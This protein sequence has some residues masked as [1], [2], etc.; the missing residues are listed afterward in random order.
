[1]PLEGRRCLLTGATG[2]IGVELARA[3]VGARV[4]LMLSGRQ[5]E[6]LN[7]L[8]E[9]LPYGS[10]IDV[11]AADLLQP[12]E[13]ER[14]ADTAR[15]AKVDTL[16]NLSG[17]NELTWLEDQDGAVIDDM[18]T[19]NLIAPIQL[20]RMLLGH[21]RESSGDGRDGLVVNVGSAFGAIGHAG[22]TAY[23]ASKFGL[24]GFSEALHRELKGN[25]VEV[26]YVAPRATQTAMNAGA[27]ESLNDALGNRSDAP[28]WVADQIVRVMREGRRSANFGWPERFFIRLNQLF[29]AVVDRAM[30]KQQA[31]IRQFARGS[32]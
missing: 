18:L 10:V 1:M 29:P 26:V 24:R 28:E 7:A 11:V 4:K 15:G 8:E 32:K 16:V 6:R 14:L 13:V 20:T 27:A 21:L 31:A 17:A 5:E 19:L 23:C 30:V 12:S 2:G 25:G 9:Q 3:L 22:Y